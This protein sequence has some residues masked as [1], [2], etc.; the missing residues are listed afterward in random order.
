MPVLSGLDATRAIR[1]VERTTGV[2]VPIV[3]MTARAMKGDREKCLEAGMDDYLSKPV[4]KTELEEV[5]RRTLSPRPSPAP[6]PAFDD[7]TALELV[8]GDEE[9][10]RQVKDLCIA[11]TPR[12]LDAAGRAVTDGQAEAAAAAAHALAGMYLV[13]GPNEVAT[14]A[15]RLEVAA[16]TGDLMAAA[17]A[18][19]A[20]RPAAAALMNALRASERAGALPRVL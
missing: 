9:T 20:L 18:Y 12:L 1:Q 19:D 16:S 17:I 13:F 14:V 2:H 6:W 7:A 8:G 11:E 10:L 4:Q 15:A 5:L 3:A